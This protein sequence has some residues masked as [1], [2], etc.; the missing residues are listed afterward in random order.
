MD[1]DDL[2]TPENV[3][4]LPKLR[5]LEVR[6][7]DVDKNARTVVSIINTAGIDRYRTVIIPK[8]G[9]LDN[10]RKNPVVLFNHDAWSAP[11]GRN[12]WIKY[13]KSQNDLIAKTYFD[14]DDFSEQLYQKV[15]SESLRAWSIRFDPDYSKCGCPTEDEI[16]AD[17]TLRD[18]IYVYRS[19]ELLEY[20]LVTIPGNADCLTDPDARAAKMPD[21]VRAYLDTLR[22]EPTPA[23][24]PE[25]T[26]APELPRLT[27][28]RTFA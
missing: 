17:K 8:G 7:D 9:K 1:P 6:V 14:T 18:C 26:P 10:Y 15:L 3:R 27:G 25:P 21:D 11:L 24:D 22:T 13:R 2:T 23:P 16:K 12:L 20:S 5:S 4:D 19:W 28:A